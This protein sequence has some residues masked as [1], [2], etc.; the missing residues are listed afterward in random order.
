MAT[1]IKRIEKDFLLKTLYDNKTL[2]TYLF[3]REEYT[4]TLVKQPNH[5]LYFKPDR[6]IEGLR[7]KDKMDL[8]FMYWGQMIKFSI[9]NVKVK[10]GIIIAEN[11]DSLFKDL[12]RSFA[13][14]ALPENL[15]IS[16]VFQGERYALGYPVISNYEPVELLES[17]KVVDPKDLPGLIKKLAHEV[18]GVA[19]GHKVFI[20]KGEKPRKVEERIICETGKIFYIPSTK[21]GLPETDPY[22]QGRIIT[23]DAFLHYLE[24]N[25][26]NPR[27]LEETLD[28]FLKLKI[29]E[30]ILSDLWVPIIFQQYVIGYIHIWTNTGGCPPLDYKAIE[31]VYQFMK[32]IA[33]SLKAQGLFESRRIKNEPFEGAIIDISASGLLAAYP[34]SSLA[35][36]L[37]PDC[38]LA[39]TIETPNRTVK[40]NARIVRRF[41]LHSAAQIYIGCQF[42]DMDP[43]DI[44][45]LFEFIYGKPFSGDEENFLKGRV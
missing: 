13:R 27:A 26:V 10:E 43:E 34:P 30:N 16:F 31:T 29:K 8:M 20:F 6:P 3:N 12:D 5:E 4:L 14:V 42:L 35:A 9:E 18:K 39:V 33:F 45:F 37:H 23:G 24:D 44:R 38:E 2:V 15:K 40:T 7:P 22:P 1:P 21:T 32:I 41:T 19:D 28:R 17:M 36:A 11:P 25:G